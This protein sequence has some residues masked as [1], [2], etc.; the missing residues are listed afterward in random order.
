MIRMG[1][2]GRQ[3]Q[4][5]M[6]QIGGSDR[7]EVWCPVRLYGNAANRRDI[8]SMPARVGNR[9]GTPFG[10]PVHPCQSHIVHPRTLMLR[11]APMASD[12]QTRSGFSAKNVR[13]S[14]A[15]PRILRRSGFIL[16]LIFVFIVYI[17]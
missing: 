1:E 13:I 4:S 2:H 15:I 17:F 16:I 6:G 14:L 9:P 3:V 7:H 12:W 10:S 8:R 5:L 11:E